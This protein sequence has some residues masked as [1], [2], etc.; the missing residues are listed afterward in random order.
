[1]QFFRNL[2]RAIWIALPMV[3]AVYVLANVAYF[4]VL[5]KEEM[6]TSQAVAVVSIISYEIHRKFCYN[7]YFRFSEIKHLA[8]SLG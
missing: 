7:F 8:I 4:V 1:M 3:T 2:P 6:Y 5:T